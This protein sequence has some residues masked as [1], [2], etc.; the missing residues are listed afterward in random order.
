MW[1]ISGARERLNSITPWFIMWYQNSVHQNEKRLH[2]VVF[3]AFWEMWN[4]FS[5]LPV[6]SLALHR[7]RWKSVTQ[8]HTHS[9][10]GFPVWLPVKRDC[11]SIVLPG[12]KRQCHHNRMKPWFSA[13]SH[14]INRR[15]YLSNPAMNQLIFIEQLWSDERMFKP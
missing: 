12:T 15:F 9:N 8:T 13:M 2:A 10:T 14:F 11:A 5:P 6:L 1:S 3:A 7:S 4:S